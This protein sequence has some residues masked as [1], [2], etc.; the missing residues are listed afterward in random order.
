MAVVYH[1]G[2]HA[3]RASGTRRPTPVPLT[4]RAKRCSRQGSAPSR[5]PETPP[6][7]AQTCGRRGTASRPPRTN[8][9][10]RP[11]SAKETLETLRDDA[12]SPLL[13]VP[14]LAFPVKRGAQG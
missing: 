12:A 10:A 9:P 4:L 8:A 2:G 14:S 1:C 6:V 11:T 7:F 3:D 13:L 5:A